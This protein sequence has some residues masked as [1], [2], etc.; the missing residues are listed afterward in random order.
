MR[1]VLTRVSEASVTIDGKV[2]GAISQGF[3]ILLG[4]T[5]E[6]SADQAVKLADK[7]CGLRIFT[8][9]NGQMNLSLT[10]VGGRL[11]V[12]SQF[13]LYGNC[14]KGRRPEFL[15]AARPETAIPLYEQFIERCKKNGIPVKAG[16]F[17][18]NMQVASIND[19]PVTLILD[20]D[21]L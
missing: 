11:L 5:H 13:T 8:D 4:I 3:L 15:W 12:I 7:I 19:G 1:A 20:T 2:K 10:D 6:D 14:K 16:V 9:E 18:A 21:D 17:G